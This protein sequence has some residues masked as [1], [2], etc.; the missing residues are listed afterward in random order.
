MRPAYTRIL[1]YCLV[2]WVALVA[3]APPVIAA[4]DRIGVYFDEQAET[5]GLS[6][7]PMV[8]FSAYVI[9]TEPSLAAFDRITFGYQLRVPTGDEVR[10]FRVL[11]NV[12]PD[13]V[14]SGNNGSAL[15]GDY[16]LRF[17]T[18]L[19]TSSATVVATW[20][21]LLLGVVEGEFYLG[22]ATTDP[23][24]DGLPDYGF[25]G[26]QV[27]L[28]VSSGATDI[29]VADINQGDDIVPIVFSCGYFEP[30]DEPA[31]PDA[32]DDVQVQLAYLRFGPGSVCPEPDLV[33]LHYRYQVDGAPTALTTVAM[34]AER[35]GSGYQFTATIPGRPDATARE[36]YITGYDP[37]TDEIV[38]RPLGSV[39]GEDGDYVTIANSGLAWPDVATA[40]VATF[41]NTVAAA[42]G[43]YD[44]DGDEDLLL[45]NSSQDLPDAV[46]RN[47]GGNSFATTNVMP[48]TALGSGTAATW[49]D[50]DNDGDLDV[51]VANE[52]RNRLWRMENGQL[53]EVTGG[54]LDVV[55]TTTAAEWVDVDHDG[56]LELSIANRGRPNQLI[57]TRYGFFDIMPNSLAFAG[58]SVGMG[59]CD[60]DRDSAPD[61][62][63]VTEGSTQHLFRQG[64]PLHFTDTP[65]MTPDAG[66]GCSWADF[67]NDGDFDVFITLWNQP[68]VLLE[69]RGEAGFV[70][71]SGTGL[72][73]AGP[74]QGAAWGDFDNDGYLDLYVA[75]NGTGNGLYHND[76]GS[77]TFTPLA[78]PGWAGVEHSIAATWCDT[79]NDGDLD[80]FVGNDGETNH[81]YR[82]DRPV[83]DNW[84]QVKVSGHPGGLQ[85]NRAAIGAIIQIEAGGQTM[86]RQVATSSGYASQAPLVQHFGLGTATVADRVTVYWP[87]AYFGG[88]H[89]A[90]VVEDVAANQK[91]EIVE[92]VI[93]VSGAPEAEVPVSRPMLRGCVPNPFN[94]QTVISFALPGRQA[95]ELAIFDLAGRQVRTIVAG[96]VLEAGEHKRSWDGRDDGGRSVAAG[97]YLV[98]VRS[99]SVA[100]SQRVTL[101]K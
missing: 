25:E 42:W 43:D 44:N 6:V 45:V 39:P 59:W 28:Q 9:I 40:A 55:A 1:P 94:P 8:P 31:A 22:P 21:Y 33:E 37:Q 26:D 17:P 32:W 93:G 82:N 29:P 38:R 15:V 63:L 50:F 35:L 23:G 46:L 70:A 60:F 92:D 98:R 36:Y 99:G 90:S 11:N 12:F 14:D 75:E 53:A 2:V 3:A 80:L 51:F 13:A 34:T 16:D 30:T 95:V 69:N 91:I 62:L 47:D 61:L 86:W 52:E 83:G 58:L 87:Y 4:P 5:A 89:H 101:V 54:P 41:G 18:P 74:S 73:S 57:H 19:P 68:D 97:V 100:E 10:V 65:L 78:I 79:D 84:L 76:G 71:L 85:S 72:E 20:Q 56:W 88:L 48:L 7:A 49:A 27:A 66:R 96:E 81:L 67:D 77:G 64:A 24:A